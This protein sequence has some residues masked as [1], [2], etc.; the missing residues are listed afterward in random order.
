MEYDA[1]YSSTLA[2]LH[3]DYVD[4]VV[5]LAV[6]GNANNVEVYVAS[7]VDVA[8]TKLG[9]F[10]ERDREDIQALLSLSHV[11]V[12]EF[13]LLAEEAIGYAVGEP[14]RLLG[15]LSTVLEEYGGDH[16]P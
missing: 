5:R 13:K 10:G 1:R 11:D 8:I 3:Y 4:R 6:Q 7:P 16:E 14:M 2:P 12:D 9:R 15:N